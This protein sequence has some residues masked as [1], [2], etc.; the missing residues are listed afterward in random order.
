MGADHHSQLPVAGR[1]LEL[2]A[3]RL[4]E[5]AGWW[6]AQHADLAAAAHDLT[7]AGRLGAGEPAP[8]RL[9]LAEFIAAWADALGQQAGE[10]ADLAAGVSATEATLGVTDLAIA[11]AIGSLADGLEHG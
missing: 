2:P 7:S 5:L 8:V 9:A 6:A 1:R 3:R 11:R 10:C 4:R